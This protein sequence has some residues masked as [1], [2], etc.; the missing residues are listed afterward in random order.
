M[1]DIKTKTISQDINMVEKFASD[2]RELLEVMSKSDVEI[3]PA[4]SLLKT[5]KTS[6]TLT[7]TQ[8]DEAK[9]ITESAYATE[10]EA[11]KELTIK[12]YLKLTGLESM[13]KLGDD[14]A[15]LK[16]NESMIRD[17]QKAIRSDIYTAISAGTGTAKGA[18]FQAACAAAWGSVTKVM[19]GEAGT[20][21]FFANPLTVASYLGTAN[22][23]T[24]TAFGMSFLSNFLG[25]GNVIIDSNVPESKVIGTVCENINI[26]AGDLA[27]TMGEM[28]TDDSGIIAV[29]NEVDY[30]KA[31]FETVAYTG[32]NVFLSFADRAIVATIG[33]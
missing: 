30:S 7:T 21:V 27:G 9:E 14:K 26:V 19:E 28:Y 33:A 16:T 10:L 25:L 23:T 3:L 6:G 8:V 2:I 31:A 1:A 32:L 29:H 4:G 12:K 20:P 13:Q 15:L 18:T 5:Y 17:I 22:I 24:Q 11:T